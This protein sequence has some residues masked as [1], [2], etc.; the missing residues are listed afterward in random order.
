M[1]WNLFPEHDSHFNF[2][3]ERLSKVTPLFLTAES[4]V[5]EPDGAQLQEEVISC[6]EQGAVFL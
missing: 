5:G 3:S 2:R 6:F 1:L 4:Q